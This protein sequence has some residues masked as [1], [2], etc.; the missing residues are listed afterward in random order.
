[1]NV[2]IRYDLVRR[3]TSSFCLAAWLEPLLASFE[4]NISHIGD[5]DT[6]KRESYKKILNCHLHLRRFDEVGGVTILQEI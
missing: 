4:V 1:M 2:P 3:E 6:T 5:Q